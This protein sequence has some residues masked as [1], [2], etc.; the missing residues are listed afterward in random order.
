M[1]EDPQV[2]GTRDERGG[3]ERPINRRPTGS[4]LP[5]IWRGDPGGKGIGWEPASPWLLLVH[6]SYNLK[7]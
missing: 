7:M 5:G 3:H 6:P 4:D 1:S 2:S